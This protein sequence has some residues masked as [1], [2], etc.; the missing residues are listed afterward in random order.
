VFWRS[1]LVLD[2]A[3]RRFR[4]SRI[5]DALEDFEVTARFERR[6]AD[7]PVAAAL[8]AYSSMTR[9]LELIHP[10][11]V[12]DA[13]L[14]VLRK[15]KL[16]KVEWCRFERSEW[17]WS[18]WWTDVV[19]ADYFPQYLATLTAHYERHLKKARAKAHT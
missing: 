8:E 5:Q 14:W 1:I 11:V 9:S 15:D 4:A 2:S 19:T 12:L 16:H 7:T 3:I 18:E 6:W 17:F 13:S 10:I